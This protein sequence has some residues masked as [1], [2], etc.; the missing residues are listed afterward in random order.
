MTRLSKITDPDKKI[1]TVY[2]PWEENIVK[3]WVKKEF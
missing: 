1:G 2:L 3:N